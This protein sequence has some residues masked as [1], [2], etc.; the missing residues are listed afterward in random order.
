MFLDKFKKKTGLV[1]IKNENILSEIII[2]DKPVIFISGHFAIL[3]S[4]K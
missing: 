4:C 1:K 3:N 2:K